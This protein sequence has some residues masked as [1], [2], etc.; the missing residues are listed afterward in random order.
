MYLDFYNLT[1]Q[2][3]NVT[4]DP[5]F[6]YMTEQ[7]ATALNHLMFG[8][9]QR[10]GFVLL[11]GEVGTGKTTLCRR[12]LSQ[13]GSRY[14]TALILNPMLTQTQL[15]R[16]VATEF[17]LQC[18]RRDRL[19]YLT[20]LNSFLLD[21]SS[22]GRDAVLIIDEAQDMSV[23]L[24]ETTRLLSNLETDSQKLLQ[25]VLAGQPELREKLRRPSLRQLAQ[26]ITVRHHLRSMTRAETARYI[27]HRLSIAG[28]KAALSFDDE[29]VNQIYEFT[30]GTPRLINAVGDKVLLAGYA[31]GR[32]TI[33]SEIVRM[34][35][36]DLKEA[37]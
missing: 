6:L 4:P 18:S 1:E 3:F 25:I 16:A 14:D 22:R 23:D 36:N 19:G 33:N 30:G 35:I 37:A 13:L 28:G 10:K 5:K 21:I 2:P 27:S 24:L 12:L 32:R 11:T 15:L 7:H 20:A 8:I 34:A 17:G 26:R 9:S 29:S 31:T